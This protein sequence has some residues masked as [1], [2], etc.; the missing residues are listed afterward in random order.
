MRKVLLGAVA[1]SLLLPTLATAEEGKWYLNPA[2]G[3]QFFDNDR[4]LDD[5]VTGLLGLERGISDD[6]ALELRFAYAEPDNDGGV[7]GLN[8]DVLAADLDLLRY[9]NSGGSVLPYAA[10]GVGVGNADYANKN[11]DQYTQLNVGGGLR[12]VTDSPLSVRADAR[13]IHGH[14]E[15]THNALIS[16]GLSYAFGGSSAPAPTSAPSDSDGDGVTDADDQCP[17]TPAGVAVD[18]KGCSLDNDGDGVPNYRDKCPTTPAGAKVDKFGCK[19]VLSLTQTESIKL[20]INFATNSDVIPASY[21]G[22]LDKVAA[23]LS[24]HDNVNAVIEGHA[25][26]RGDAAY[27]KD[28]SQRRAGA[29]KN[30]LSKNYGIAASRLSASGYG[31]ERPVASNDNE[32]GRK[33]NR[34]VVAVVQTGPSK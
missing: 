1:T 34:R 23:F 24:K 20:E 3:Y 9:F 18:A 17:A 6:Y 7:A 15:D 11:E 13:Y 32:E 26:S 29:V 4:D 31:E 19:F 8:A 12:F 14:D 10:L 21:S 5:E 22:E 27:N 16:L 33:A 25:D 30:A 2:I 28:L